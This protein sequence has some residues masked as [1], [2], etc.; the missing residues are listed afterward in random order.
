MKNI[1]ELPALIRLENVTLTVE[2]DIT[3]LRGISWNIRKGERWALFGRNGSGK[4][5]LLEL[6][7]GYLHQTS[8]EIYRFGSK[9][10]DVREARKKIGYLSTP[11]KN[12][13]HPA[14]TILEVVESG[15]YASIGIYDEVTERERAKALALL[16]RIGME[17]R[18][19]DRFAYLSDGEK[20]KTLFSRVLMTDPLLVILDEPA[21]GLDLKAREDLLQTIALIANE[22]DTAFVYVTHHTEEIVPSFTKTFILERGAGVY[23]GSIAEGLTAERLSALF[24]TAVDVQWRNGRIYTTVR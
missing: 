21:T 17:G 24:E 7:V 4:T 2:R 8:G 22:R 12:R 16:K 10:C 11:L 6:I 1:N 5:K 20:Q 15:A 9:L 13:F 14:D 19:N 3:L 23:A 18:E